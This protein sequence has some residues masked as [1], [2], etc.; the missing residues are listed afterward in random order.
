M[1]HTLSYCALI[2]KCALIRSNKV[3]EYWDELATLR[4]QQLTVFAIIGLRALCYP[5]LLRAPDKRGI[6]HNSKIIFLIS[7]TKTY[8]VVTHH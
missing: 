4:H 2:G 6:E 3:L 7:Q 5:Y 8:N 1:P